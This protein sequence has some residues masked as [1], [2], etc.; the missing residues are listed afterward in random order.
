MVGLLRSQG[1]VEGCGQLPKTLHLG[2]LGDYYGP[3]V[4]QLPLKHW[5][6]A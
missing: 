3:K 4:P 2:L 6:V 5:P 1:E